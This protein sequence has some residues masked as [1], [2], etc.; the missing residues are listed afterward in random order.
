MSCIR[1]T[2]ETCP[3][4]FPAFWFYWHLGHPNTWHTD[5]PFFRFLGLLVFSIYVQFSD[6]SV[7]AE[8]VVELQDLSHYEGGKKLPIYQKINNQRW[9]TTKNI[10]INLLFKPDQN[11]EPNIQYLTHQPPLAS[12]TYKMVANFLLSLLD[13]ILQN[14]PPKKCIEHESL[15]K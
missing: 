9:Q 14:L 7:M 6:M 10:L 13:K 4:T 5:F 2:M 1:N 11:V 8:V 12:M 3:K 15:W